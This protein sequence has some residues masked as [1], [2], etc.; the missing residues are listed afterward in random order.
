MGNTSVRGKDIL[1]DKTPVL[2]FNIFS[3]FT[4][5]N[6]ALPADMT[7]KI[8]VTADT[9]VS[10]VQ[11]F[12]LGIQV[13]ERIPYSKI[14]LK[15]FGKSPFPFNI[16]L[17]MDPVGLDKTLFHIELDAELNSMMKMMVGKRL[18]KVVDSL[19]DQIEK[20][21]FHQN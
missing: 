11:G 21:I 16:S 12:K 19:S 4:K 2:I 17:N 15:E 6:S 1:I 3:D 18:Q 20:A 7:Q 9:I 5:F 8:E 14:I 13:E 10:E